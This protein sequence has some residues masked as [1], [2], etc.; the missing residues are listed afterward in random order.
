MSDD[1]LENLTSLTDNL[2]DIAFTRYA[3]ITKVND[4]GTVDC[5]EDNETIHQNV[6]N[7][8]NFKLSI[9]DTVLLGFVDNN[10]YNPMITGGVT[11]KAADDTMIYALGL[12]KFNINENGHLIL[13]LPIGVDNYFSINNSGHLIVDLDDSTMEEKFSINDE[14]CV[15]YDV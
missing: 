4:D 7:S 2:N 11:V 6:I 15:I 10:I 14:G 5:Q 9:G 1:F 12:G 8:T 3:T 13:T